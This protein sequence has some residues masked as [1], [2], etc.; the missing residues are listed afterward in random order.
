V[1]KFFAYLWILFQQH[2]FEELISVE[3]EVRSKVWV[4]TRSTAGIAGSSTAES[5]G[6]SSVV[7]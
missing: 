3:V 5:T 1:W 4:C 6:F 7:C 2:S